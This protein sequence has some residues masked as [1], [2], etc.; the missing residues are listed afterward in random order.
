MSTSLFARYKDTVDRGLIES[1]EGQ[2]LVL[3]KL[4]KLRLALADYQPALEAKRPV[5]SVRRAPRGAFSA[6][7]LC[8]GFGRARQND[9][10]GFLLRGSSAAAQAPHPFSRLHGGCAC[11]HLRLA[12]GGPAQEGEGRRSDRGSGG[13]HRRRYRAALFRRIPRH[14][15]HR[16]DDSRAP[17]HGLVRARRRHCRDL[18]RRARRPLQGRPQPR[19]I[20]SLHRAHQGA[21][22][23]R[24]TDRAHRLPPRKTAGPAKAGMFPPTKRRR[25][26]SP[27]P[28]R[29]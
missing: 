16:R 22:G 18:Q 1:D 7:A 17:V 27:A 25:P 5:A 28:S 12:A 29:R 20:R 3:R 23:S 24:R 6:G 21:H 15:H 26:P 14:R 19:A 9:A 8:L 13:L 11:G 2:H 10:D 4:E